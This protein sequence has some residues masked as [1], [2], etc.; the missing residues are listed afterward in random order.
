MFKFHVI[1]FPLLLAILGGACVLQSLK[2]T[3]KA[4]DNRP[5]APKANDRIPT[6]HFNCWF[7]QGYIIGS[8]SHPPRIHGKRKV[9]VRMSY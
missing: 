8:T 4:P 7:Q 5:F 2:L 6:I 1:V 9:E 3:A